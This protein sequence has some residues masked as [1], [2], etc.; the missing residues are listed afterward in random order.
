MYLGNC[1]ELDCEHFSWCGD[2]YGHYNTECFCDLL[3]RNSGVI[4]HEA[5]SGDKYVECPLGK[6]LE[7]YEE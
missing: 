3:P 7:N 1:E 5:E 6:V 2:H 4:R